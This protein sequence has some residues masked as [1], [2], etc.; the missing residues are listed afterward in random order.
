MQRRQCAVC[1]I[2]LLLAANQCPTLRAQ[3]PEAQPIPSV[4]LAHF[5]AT[6]GVNLHMEY[7]DGK[8]ADAHAVLADLNYLGIHAVRDDI[9]QSRWMPPGQGVA[10]MR[11]LGANGIHFDLVAPG[12]SSVPADLEQVHQ[13]LATTP[14]MVEAIEG[15]NEIN[16]WPVKSAGMSGEQAAESFQRTLYRAV[17]S[18]ALTHE[19]PVYYLTGGQPVDLTTDQG[20]ADAANTH[21]YPHNGEQPYAWL[22]RDF[23]TYFR[24]ADRMPRVLTET[25]YYTLPQSSDWGG[26]DETAQAILL[27]NTYFDAALQGADRTFVYQLLDPY[28]DPQDKNSDDHFGFFRLDGSPKKSATAMHNLATF[29]PPDKPSAHRELHATVTGLPAGTGH[30]LALTVS[31]GMFAVFLWNE[32]PVWNEATHSPLQV[33]PV[34]VQVHLDGTW[35]VQYFDPSSAALQNIPQQENSFQTLVQS[36]PTALLFRHK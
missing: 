32:A 7:T 5:Q 13:L 36:W 25:G 3:S 1:W 9:P 11:L 8:Y 2:F 15:P 31:D 20:L 29:F 10:A 23:G 34:P 27:L 14:G 17:K 21:P 24:N 28:P 4:P 30:A 18:N 6:L 16:N 26:V 22:N 19:L 33:A 35:A 12:D